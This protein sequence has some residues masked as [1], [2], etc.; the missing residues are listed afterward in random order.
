MLM[1]LPYLHYCEYRSITQA[2]VEVR[3][4]RSYAGHQG[5]VPVAEPD[6]H[7]RASYNQAALREAVQ[8]A[9]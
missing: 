1:L 5:E 8:K 6:A 3:H 9:H 2:G 4:Q 7:Q